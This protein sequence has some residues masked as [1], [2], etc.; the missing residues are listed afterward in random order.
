MP[1]DQEIRYAL[2][3]FRLKS[4]FRFNK[5]VLDRCGMDF[6]SIPIT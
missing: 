2:K 6:E 1:R 3:L 5:M 4:F